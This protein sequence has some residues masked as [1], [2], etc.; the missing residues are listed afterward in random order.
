MIS[1]S[2]FYQV[3]YVNNENIDGYNVVILENEK[4]SKF[5]LLSP[6]PKKGVNKLPF[7]KYDS[8]KVGYLYSVKL[9][10]QDTAYVVKQSFILDKKKT[11]KVFLEDQVFIQNDTIK[12]KVYR[13]KDVYDSFVR[14]K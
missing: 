14:V 5:I 8:I 1:S 6:R 4:N 3:I 13:S 11:Y 9:V 2:K 7:S 10:P 12:A